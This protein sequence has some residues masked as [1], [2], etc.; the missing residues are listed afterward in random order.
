MMC[1]KISHKLMSRRLPPLNALRAFEAAGRHQSF[2]RAAEELSVSHSAISKHVRGLEH[3][4]GTQL[5]RDL[6]RGVALTPAGARYLSTLTPAFDAI[7]EAS[8]AFAERPRGSFVL[9]S[10]TSFAVKW[11][12]PN[13]GSFYDAYPDIEVE[14]EA[15]Q[16]LADL[17]RYEADVAIRFFHGGVPDRPA[18]LISNARVYPYATPALAEEIGGDPANFLT[19]RLLRD[20]SGDPWRDWFASLGRED[21]Y[22]RA[23]PR[24]RMRA[25]LSHQSAVAGL[26]ILLAS[27]EN[28]A[29][30]VTDGKLVRLNDHGLQQGSYYMLLGQGAQ[31]RKPVRVF[32][33]WLLERTRAFRS[34]VDDSKP[35]G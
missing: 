2:S 18:E 15:T 20:R 31:R 22:T 27:E 11:L 12:T 3:H 7:G 4:L 25:V 13:L 9:N 17:E 1:E 34:A 28:V 6:P 29:M 19:Y 32:R 16:A 30:D 8:D 21:L 10:D 14:L 35:L 5:F 23:P 33:E 26:G 24:W